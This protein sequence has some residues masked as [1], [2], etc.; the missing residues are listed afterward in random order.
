MSRQNYYK[1]R[2]ARERRAVDEGGVVELVKG[3]RRIQPR[4]GTRKLQVVLGSEFEAMGIRMGRDRLFE[5]L[6]GEGLLVERKRR[7][8]PVSGTPRSI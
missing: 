5:V 8:S 2:K 1:V 7:R 3:E 6:R 4:L